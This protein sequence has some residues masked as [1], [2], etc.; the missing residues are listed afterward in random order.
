ML[1][2]CL[3]ICPEEIFAKE[4]TL[5]GALVNPFTYKRAVA[6]AATMAER[7]LDMEKLGV[8]IFRL[9]EYQ[10]ALERLSKG[11]IAKAMFNI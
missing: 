11:S 7:Y 2:S 8:Q 4:L 1:P 10:S 3:S 5:F 9:D 6:L